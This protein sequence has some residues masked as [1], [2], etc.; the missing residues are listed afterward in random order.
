MTSKF[1]FRISVYDPSAFDITREWS[2]TNIQR[3]YD[4]MADS[5]APEK[6]IDQLSQ[7]TFTRHLPFWDMPLKGWSIILESSLMESPAEGRSSFG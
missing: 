1:E 3:D 5:T 6:T 2:Y 4:P 7:G